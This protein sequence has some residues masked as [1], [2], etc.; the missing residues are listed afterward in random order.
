M[1]QNNKQH[2]LLKKTS[3]IIEK[4]ARFFFI[5]IF[6]DFLSL[7]NRLYTDYHYS[8]IKFLKSSNLSSKMVALNKEI[9][10][11]SSQ[12]T[13]LLL[14]YKV[15]K[16]YLWEICL[17]IIL[18]IIDVLSKIGVSLMLA[19][20]ITSL[21]K[22]ENLLALHYS[23]GLIFL[24]IIH[25]FSGQ[26]N[27]YLLNKLSNS[28]K[29]SILSA[30]YS[31]TLK[32]STSKLE[33]EKGK[34]YNII[35][36]DMNL[37]ENKASYLLAILMTPFTL[38]VSIGLLIYNF[39]NGAYYILFGLIIIFS[40]QYITAYL[41][42][43]TLNKKAQACDSRIKS[44]N[45]LIEQIR[46]IKMLGWEDVFIEE[47]LNK[48]EKE[49][50]WLESTNILLVSNKILAK[51]AP[52]IL[53]LILLSVYKG[54]SMAQR[55]STYQL[56]DFVSVYTI[57][58][59]GLGLLSFF[60]YRLVFQRLSNVLNVSESTLFQKINNKIYSNSIEIRNFDAEWIPG[61]K[62]LNSI[63]LTIK[64]KEK[65][66]FLGKIASGKTSLFLSILNQIPKTEG[67]IEINGS[68]AF[69]EQNPFLIAG[70]LRENI[71]FGLNY[72]KMKY[73]KILKACL[74]DEDFKQFPKGDSTLVG[75]RGVC[76]SGGQKSRGFLKFNYYN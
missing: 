17:C 26:H 22:K 70:S 34:L 29:L 47:I 65:I 53:T 42:V 19:N 1:K 31:K 30:L 4:L 54:T 25:L 15:F 52:F 56:L 27:W 40:L 74:L 60:E 18:Y 13:A 11:N 6:L 7:R 67:N 28:L 46:N 68:L 44:T 39:N 76:L 73:E 48:R 59:F 24:M 37:L 49:V 41:N 64:K 72:D 43:K 9:T 38:I 12:L 69:V 51:I 61:K 36:S 35:S 2:K 71:L 57:L 63:N 8:T 45:E 32:L 33:L 21:N 62:C 58:Y 20:V 14:A 55:F 75:E 23:I 50:G 3:K 66:A 16:V 5:D 10:E